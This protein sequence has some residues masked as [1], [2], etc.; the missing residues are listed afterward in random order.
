MALV[1]AAFFF[2]AYVNLRAN[3]YL[4]FRSV[5]PNYRHSF[6]IYQVSEAKKPYGETPFRLVLYGGDEIIMSFQYLLSCDGKLLN[7]K[8]FRIDWKNKG[9]EVK[10]LEGANATVLI[11]MAYDGK[12]TVSYPTDSD[13]DAD[14]VNGEPSPG[15]QSR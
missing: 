7:Q 12:V 6:E 11:T 8:S 2:L 15:N 14:S 9:V 13:F 5:S 4:V 1:L 10:Q 3:D